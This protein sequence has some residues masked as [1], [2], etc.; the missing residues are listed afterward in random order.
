MSSVFGWLGEIFSGL[1]Q[2]LPRRVL[3]DPTMEA[4]LFKYGTRGFVAKHNNGWGKTGFHVYIPLVTSIYT[5]TILEQNIDLFPQLL[6]TEDRVKVRLEGVLVCHIIDSLKLATKG[7]E[8]EEIVVAKTTAAIKGLVTSSS[9][10]FV[11]SSEFDDE[12]YDLLS[13][14]LSEYGIEVD[15]IT[16]GDVCD[17]LV[18]VTPEK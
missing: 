11:L 17:V 4:V 16:L 15:T 6:M 2:F 8:M 3:I 9:Y 18:I 5:N 10:D 13:E 12:L 1:I 7:W 14:E